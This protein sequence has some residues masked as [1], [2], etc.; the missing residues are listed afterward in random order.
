M[1]T[2]QF[3]G[4]PRIGVQGD[5][6]SL[7]YARHWLDQIGL[8]TAPVEELEQPNI[9]LIAG[10]N[11]GADEPQIEGCNRVFLWDFQTGMSGGGLHAAAASGV[12]WVLGRPNGLPL[13]MPVDVPEKW[14][15]LIG[16]N[17]AVSVLL[18]FSLKQ[19]VSPRRVD[20]S[21]ADTLRSFADQNSGNETDM[22]HYWQRNGHTA[23]GHGGIYPQGYYACRDGYVGVIGR[24]RKDWLAI[25][26][27]IGQPP[28]AAEE[29]FGDPFVL[30]DDSTEVDDL[31][32]TALQGFDRD[33]LLARAVKHGAPLAPV[34]AEDEL[35]AR[36]VVRK[37]FFN[38]D[39]SA[40]LPFEI[41]RRAD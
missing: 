13:A 2:L 35:V 24:S 32:S 23:V 6:A 19:Q 25:R 29:R 31:L 15:G 7:F 21:A 34:Y 11:D 26:E 27:V 20:I 36:D 38:A 33:D 8:K 18:E 3:S 10:A 37:G 5:N 1:R 14:C 22:D 40:N 41:V 17:F 28:W 9:L 12:S 16:A 30:A 4:R 39:G